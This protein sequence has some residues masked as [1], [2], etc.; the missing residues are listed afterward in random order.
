SKTAVTANPYRVCMLRPP[1]GI[2]LRPEAR[3]EGLAVRR[4][5]P[6]VARDQVRPIVPHVPHPGEVAPL[7]GVHPV[8]Q[9]RDECAAAIVLAE[10]TEQERHLLRYR[11]R[12]RIPAC[13]RIT[14]A[15]VVD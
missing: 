15:E 10:L 11:S 9:R 1:G 5:G 4:R 13:D 7:L 12:I 14:P 8:H 2:G 3:P 6:V